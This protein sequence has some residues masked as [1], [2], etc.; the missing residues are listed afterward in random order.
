MENKNETMVTR[1]DQQLDALLAIRKV[2]DS[3]SKQ[4]SD[5]LN[6]LS[7]VIEIQEEM[8]K[9]TKKRVTLSM[10]STA[11]VVIGVI[12]I[13]IAFTQLIG[14][15]TQLSG[16]LNG[17]TTQITGLVTQVGGLD[18]AG[19]VGNITGLTTTATDTIAAASS[20]I[21]TTLDG[22]NKIDFAGLNSTITSLNSLSGALNGIVE[23][24]A[25]V[26]TKITGLLPF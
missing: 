13:V 19:L 16:T 9:A 10:I 8:Q 17:M 5:V 4:N 12:A 1:D 22:I 2:L 23:N 18:F 15:I 24:L 20:G 25:N 14:P 6:R 7:Q 3:Q 21:Q 11:A 26:V